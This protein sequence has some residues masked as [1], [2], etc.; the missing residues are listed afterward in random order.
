MNIIN[1]NGKL[2]VDSREVAE[3]TDK[4][5]ADLIRDIDGY[6]AII[7][8]NANLRSDQFFIESDYVAG[9]GKSYRCYLLT[10]KGCDMVA[11]KMTGEKGV[12]FTAAYVIKFEEMERQTLPQMSPTELIAALANQ[13]VEQ[14]K[15]VIALE[16]RVTETVETMSTIQETLLKRDDDW[17]KS[18][19]HMINSSAFRLSENYRE[20]RQRSYKLLEDRARCDL[21]ARLRNLVKRLEEAGATKSQIKDANRMDVIESEPRLKEIYSAIVKEISIG[22]MRFAR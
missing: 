16:A 15:R 11:N 3:M 7:D 18:I 2:L 19:N 22:S 10:R 8:Q 13:A 21:D 17:R 5:H 12:L 4:R 14:E 9:T 1:R 6:K 20:I